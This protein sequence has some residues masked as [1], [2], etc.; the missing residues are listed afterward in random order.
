[1]VKATKKSPKSN[2]AINLHKINKGTVFEHAIPIPATRPRIEEAKS[3]FL[4]EKASTRYARKG[5]G[6][7]LVKKKAPKINP[8]ALG[9]VIPL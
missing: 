4:R 5:L 9:S 8:T 3:N 2:P 6:T 7:V 1:V